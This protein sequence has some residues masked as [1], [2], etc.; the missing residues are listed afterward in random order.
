MTKRQLNILIGLLLLFGVVYNLQFCMNHYLFRTNGLDYGFYNQVYWE[1]A[2]LKS[3]GSTIFEPHLK[4]FLQIHP[5]FTLYILSPLYWVFAPLFGTYTLGFIQS[6]FILAGGL[7]TFL[8]LREKTKNYLFSILGMVH[9]NLIWGHFSAISFEYIDATVASAIV[10]LFLYFFEKKKYFISILLFL[11]TITSR[12]NMPIWFLFIAI[13]LFITNF[14]DKQKA[15]YS[16][17]LF[18]FSLLYLLFLFKFLIPFFENPENPYWGFAYSS[19]GNNLI[20][21][22]ITT[23]TKPFYVLKLLFINQSG[24]PLYNG[25]KLEFYYVF[26]LSGG[27]IL[28]FRPVMI[29]PFIPIIAQKMLNDLYVRWGINQ[30]YS[31]EI[32]TILSAYSFLAVHQQFNRKKNTLITLA[33]ILCVVTLSVTIVKMNSRVSKWYQEE[34]ENIYQSSFYKS[35]HNIKSINKALKILPENATICA[36]EA[37]VPHL[38]FRDSIYMFPYMWNAEYLAILKNHRT[39]PMDQNSFDEKLN[40]ILNSNEWWIIHRKDS[41]LILKRKQ[42]DEINLAQK[43]VI[44]CSADSFNVKSNFIYTNIDKYQCYN[45]SQI[46][47]TQARSGKYSVRVTPEAQFGMTITLD[48]IIIGTK[49][50]AS[51]WKNKPLPGAFLVLSSN[52]SNMFYIAEDDS[53]LKDTLSWNLI[54]INTEIKEELTWNQL[55]IYVWNSSDQIVNFD[56]FIIEITNP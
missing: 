20:E 18:G 42:K 23:L 11:F 36:S 53:D 15:L 7:G 27:L 10:P 13:F 47:S 45:S 44:S 19:L 14:R 51:I 39:Y 5:A 37:L 2:H 3:P 33:V 32:V 46:D 30:F 25:I 48:D 1:I 40:S 54:S 17:T 31:I 28:L 43:L 35:P 22:L 6:L 34:K 41:L 9:Y 16:L 8:F 29:I 21:A 50:Q 56:D 12:E 4:S 52:K 38:S 55:K 24:D 26:A 49:I